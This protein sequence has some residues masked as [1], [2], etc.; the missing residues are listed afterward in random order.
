MH[1]TEHL[2]LEKM[3]FLVAFKCFPEN[4]GYRISCQWEVMSVKAAAMKFSLHL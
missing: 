3:F 4:D 1:L 2:H